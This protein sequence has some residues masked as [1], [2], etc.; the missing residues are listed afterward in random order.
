MGVEELEGQKEL[1]LSIKKIREDIKK[2]RENDL[3]HIDVRI[4]NLERKVRA[5]LTSL[6][7][8]AAFAVFVGIVAVVTFSGALAVSI[9]AICGAIL[10]LSI[11]AIRKTIGIKRD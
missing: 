11:L 2:I 9:A 1:N 10:V 5:P 4:S 6:Y 3:A 8:I 7:M